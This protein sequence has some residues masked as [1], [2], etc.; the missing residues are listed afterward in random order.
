MTVAL[1]IGEGKT[2]KYKVKTL[3]GVVERD[4]SWVIAENAKNEC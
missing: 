2:D 1:F 3:G 4:C